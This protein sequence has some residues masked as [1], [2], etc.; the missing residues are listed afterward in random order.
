MKF[1]TLSGREIR[2]EIIASRY[3]PRSR[4]AS[5]SFGQ[6]NLGRQIQ[7]IYGIKALLLE[8]FP[9][10][11][12]RLS[13][14]FYMPHHNLAFEF[15]GVQH[16]EYNSHFHGDKQGFERQKER[17]ERKRLWCELN[18]IT[19]IEIRNSSISSAELQM[20]IQEARDDGGL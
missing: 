12:T 9:I 10:P 4:S 11:E 13:L 6:F 19:L 15:Q 18:D 5:R 8:E 3:A 17:D 14:D 7:A 20:M 2:F 16:D 1:R